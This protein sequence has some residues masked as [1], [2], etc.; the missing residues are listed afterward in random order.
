MFP[1]RRI[2]RV[3]ALL[4]SAIT[5]FTWA[6]SALVHLQGEVG[7]REAYFANFTIVSDRTPPDRAFES[8]QL[9][10]LDTVVVYEE[11]GKPEFVA[12]RLQFECTVKYALDGKNPPPQPTF[13]APVKVRIG[14][15]SWSLRRQE[16]KADSLPVGEWR[17]AA[18]PALLKLQKIACNDDVMR[19]AVV[20][21][22]KQKGDP[23]V[24]EREIK[25]IGLPQDLQL[26][27]QTLASEYLDF[28]WQVLWVGAQ[29]PDP[30]GKWSR[31]STPQEL[32]AARAEIEKHRNQLNALVAKIQPGLEAGVAKSAAEL[33]FRQAAAQIRGDRAISKNERL[34]LSVW[35][36][37]TET[38]IG[39]AMG[40]PLVSAAGKLRFL[41][42]GKE[43]DNRVILANNAGAV[44]EQ[45]VYESCN[46]QFV[47][48]PDDKA[49]EMR[50]ADVRIWA[51]ANQ[52]GSGVSACSGLLEVP[53]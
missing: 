33:D 8:I 21:S 24:F 5:P 23:Q 13:D 11:A 29:R 22:A 19:S 4:S 14:A 34:M 52:Y 36:G 45:G 28:A 51:Q 47:L 17:S 48:L 16:L 41:S 9:R 3:L 7:H 37:K 53:R 15:N 30:S 2:A 20:Q 42:Y 6:Q 26:L 50:V 35:E 31:R 25:K 40:A 32:Q 10:E 18:S 46:V 38:D 44:W 49:R 27:S 39:A 12:L 43:F 1:M